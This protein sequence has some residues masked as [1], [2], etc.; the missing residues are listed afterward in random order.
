M[1]TGPFIGQWVSMINGTWAENEYKEWT[2]LP[3][4]NIFIF[5]VIFIALAVLPLLFL[6]KKEKSNNEQAS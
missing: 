6:I 1:V 4:E 3:N 5:A 2:V